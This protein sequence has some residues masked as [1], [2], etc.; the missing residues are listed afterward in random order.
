M[1]P[2]LQPNGQA[3]V[4]LKLWFQSDL[5]KVNVKIHFH[6]RRTA[7]GIFMFHNFVFQRFPDELSSSPIERKAI[8]KIIL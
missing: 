3:M 6:E 4:D 8:F 1:V 5:L 2:Y 7:E